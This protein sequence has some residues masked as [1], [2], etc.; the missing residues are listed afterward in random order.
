MVYSG[1]GLVVAAKGPT[2]MQRRS[3]QQW[4]L[5]GYELIDELEFPEKAEELKK[6]VIALNGAIKCPEGKKDIILSDDQV[7]LQVHESCG[8]PIERD[9]AVGSEER[10]A[11]RSFLTPNNS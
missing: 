1:G 11:G 5:K 10:V 4:M 7:G 6:D 9:R 2:G 3:D 8:H